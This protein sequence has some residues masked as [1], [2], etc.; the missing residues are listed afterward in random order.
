MNRSYPK[1][2]IQLAGVAILYCCLYY[3]M[4]DFL[5]PRFYDNFWKI[6]VFF[7]LLFA[8]I[9]FLRLRQST[10]SSSIRFFMASTT[11]KMFLLLIILTI[12]FFI[13]RQNAIPFAISFL[14]AYFLFMIF[15][16]AKSYKLMKSGS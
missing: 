7:Y 12:Y 10:G 14:I 6:A 2:L 1:Y 9:H 13:N 8:A 5:M 4:R 11:I 3:M 15:D 16:V